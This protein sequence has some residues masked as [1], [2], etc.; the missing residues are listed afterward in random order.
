M[1]LL[2]RSLH[3]ETKQRNDSLMVK[4]R[5]WASGF[6][7][8]RYDAVET[9]LEQVSAANRDLSWITLGMADQLSF[10]YLTRAFKEIQR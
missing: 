3:W 10:W 5:K 8:S 9:W 4:N 6:K 1:L 7:P 2:L